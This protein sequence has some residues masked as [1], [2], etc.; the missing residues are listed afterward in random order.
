MFLPD[1]QI[2]AMRDSRGCDTLDKTSHTELG[3][4]ALPAR[5]V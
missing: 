3:V 2:D 4:F 1:Q 5:N